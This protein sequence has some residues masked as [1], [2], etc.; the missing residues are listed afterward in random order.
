LHTV[1]TD[2]LLKVSYFGECWV[3]AACAEEIAEGFEGDTASPALIEQGERL[4][5]VGACLMD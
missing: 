3:L 5:I 1:T 4:F 2:A